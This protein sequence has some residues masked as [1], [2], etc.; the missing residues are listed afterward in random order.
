VNILL[1]APP[2]MDYV[3]DVLVP[4]GMDAHRECPP[5]GMY[6]L[7]QALRD[8]GHEVE[9][10]D[11][12]AVGT[13]DIQPWQ[14][15]VARAEM[16][17]IGCTSMSWA[18][19]RDIVRQI[20]LMAEH[21]P[22]VLGGIHPTMFDRYLLRTH[23]VDY[24]IRGEGESALTLLV[25]ALA[26]GGKGSQLSEV[27]NL[28]WRTSG[29]EIIQNPTAT[30]LNPNQIAGFGVP[31]YSELPKSVYHSLSIESS[32]GC[33]FD[34]SF[35]S[36]SYRTTSRRLQPSIFVDRLEKIL[37][38]IE[39]TLYK[40][41]HIIDDEFSMNPKR[42]IEIAKEMH[43]RG[44]NTPLIYDSRANDL[45]YPGYVEHIAP[46]TYQFLIGAECGYDDG[47]M[48]IG[49]GTT[50]KKLEDAAKVLHANGIADRADYSFILGLP[51]ETRV[52]VDKTIEFAL[53]LHAKYGVR[54]LLQWYCEIPGS[55][56]WQRDYDEGLVT[57]AMYDDYGFFSDLYLFRTAVRLSP[58]EIYDISGT[59]GSIQAFAN[60]INGRHVVEHSFPA[61]IA[62][63]F[64]RE[65]LDSKAAGLVNLRDVAH[66]PRGST[67]ESEMDADGT[68]NVTSVRTGIPL[69]HFTGVHEKL[70]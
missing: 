34:C 8:A 31:D 23:A 38:H 25:Q 56:L 36:T 42:V 66:P 70:S 19:A 60:A 69:R 33:A 45:L 14:L 1:I 7:T 49:K 68:S 53:D 61:P 27:P 13:R 64:P 35:C 22:I 6:L 41:V 50:C 10:L 32:R 51:W 9:I 3:D 11:L 28:S 46:L 12:I 20:R 40:T 63:Y 37:P 26:E 24:V 4:I 57:P 67:R 62:R 18:T 43:R 52:E 39:R 29:G 16:I 55:R 54:I 48:R 44:L 59:I 47:L 65:S 30:K 21:V 2:I 15:Q 58:R 5:Y 17:G